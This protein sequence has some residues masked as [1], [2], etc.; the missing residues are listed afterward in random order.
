[1]R[2]LGAAG[3]IALQTHLKN[4]RLCRRIFIYKNLTSYLP[5]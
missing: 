2:L 3:K 4:L 5:Y 1:M